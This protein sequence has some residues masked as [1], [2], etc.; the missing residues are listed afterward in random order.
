MFKQIL[1]PMDLTDAHG[2]AL[3]IAADLAGQ[4]RAAKAA[5]AGPASA[6]I[7]SDT[8]VLRPGPQAAGSGR[9]ERH[10]AGGGS[11]DSRSELTG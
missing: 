11:E 9:L 2:R 8:A 5:V 6:C 7:T 10:P 4:G 3:D 1:V